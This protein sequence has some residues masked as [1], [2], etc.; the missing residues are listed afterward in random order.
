MA[1]TSIYAPENGIKTAGGRADVRG[2]EQLPGFRLPDDA[3]YVDAV[4]AD[5]VR[6]DGLAHFQRM[7]KQTAHGIAHAFA[8]G[9]RVYPLAAG[10]AVEKARE[11]GGRGLFPR[12]AV[13]TGQLAPQA[14]AGDERQ[15]GL[16]FLSLVLDAGAEGAGVVVFVR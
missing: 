9:R 16:R 15:G 7:R 10:G 5:A 14:G 6:A 12:D 4:R 11:D 3:V 2:D 13:R 8:V 1:E